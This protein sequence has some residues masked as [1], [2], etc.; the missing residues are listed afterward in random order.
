MSFRADV[1]QQPQVF[2][3]IAAI[4]EIRVYSAEWSFVFVVSI[5]LP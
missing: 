1:A 3:A 5:R 2:Y 4:G